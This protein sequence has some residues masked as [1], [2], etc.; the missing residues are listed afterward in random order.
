MPRIAKP[1]SVVTRRGNPGK[2]KYNL[3]RALKLRI[4]QGISYEAI[5][6]IMHVDPSTVV[7]GLKP[8]EALLQNPELVAASQDH[9]PTLLDSAKLTLLSSMVHPERIAKASVNNL[10][11]AM[12]QVD[13]ISRLDRGQSTSNVSGLL[14]VI[15]DA[16]LDLPRRLR[17]LPQAQVEDSTQDINLQ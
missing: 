6:R 7:R 5:A 17:A 8:L 10:A 13:T 16:H 12:T 1:L 14:R 15:S 3:S 11:Y 2:L 9:M 4:Q